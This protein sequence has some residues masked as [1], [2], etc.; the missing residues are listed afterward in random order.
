MAD[1]VLLWD[2]VEGPWDGSSIIQAKSSQSYD[3]SIQC[4]WQ[5]MNL[6]QLWFGYT[7]RADLT[8]KHIHASLSQ[9]ANNGIQLLDTELVLTTKLPANSNNNQFGYVAPVRFKVITNVSQ[10]GF[11]NYNLTFNSYSLM[12]GSGYVWV[13]DRNLITAPQTNWSQSYPQSG[14]KAYQF[15]KHPTKNT[16]F[17]FKPAGAAYLYFYHSDGTLAD[18]QY[19]AKNERNGYF[20]YPADGTSDEVNMHVY[21]I[22]STNAL[23]TISQ[24]TNDPTPLPSLP[25]NYGDTLS[26]NLQQ[27]DN[28]FNLRQT[29]ADSY[30]FF[31]V[32][33]DMIQV[34]FALGSAFYRYLYLTDSTGKVIAETGEIV[35]KDTLLQHTLPA[36]GNYYIVCT[37]WEPGYNSSTYTVN[38]RKLN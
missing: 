4:V 15:A 32:Q 17:S 21:A 10:P 13:A 22:S 16:I 25:I 33:G 38:L 12:D 11:I 5:G 9:P 30:K 8:N 35:G 19:V 26:G 2:K 29:P 34:D 36:D 14:E 3:D 18:M 37:F 6:S 27:S 28:I 24:I 31:G 23:L 7:T 20:V 1:T